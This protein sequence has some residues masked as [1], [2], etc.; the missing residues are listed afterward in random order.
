MFQIVTVYEELCS[1]VT[2]IARSLGITASV[3][4][5]EAMIYHW[6]TESN[7]LRDAYFIGLRGEEPLY[8]VM[9]L[10]LQSR[11]KPAD[12][13][14][15]P[16]ADWRREPELFRFATI[17]LHIEGRAIT[18][19]MQERYAFTMA[20]GMLLSAGGR[21]EQFAPK[22]IRERS[23]GQLMFC[24]T[25]AR[26]CIACG[27]KSESDHWYPSW[28]T[29]G[30]LCYACAMNHTK[31]HM[32]CTTCGM[33]PT[34]LEWA[35]SKH[36]AKTTGHGEQLYPC[37]SCNLNTGEDPY[38]LVHSA[39]LPGMRKCASCGTTESINWSK[40]W[41]TDRNYEL[42]GTCGRRWGNIKIHCECG[43]V[44]FVRQVNT[45]LAD[46]NGYKT[47]GCNECAKPISVGPE[48]LCISCHKMVTNI[49]RPSWSDS[50]GKLCVACGKLY[51][52]WQTYCKTCKRVPPETDLKKS[53]I[54]EHGNRVF[55]CRNCHP[56]ESKRKKT[57]CVSCGTT[58]STQWL[59]SWYSHRLLCNE[60]GCRYQQVKKYCAR[61]DFVFHSNTD[62][63]APSEYHGGS[64]CKCRRPD[65]SEVPSEGPKENTADP[66]VSLDVVNE[67]QMAEE[68]DL[69]KKVQGHT[70]SGTVTAP[71]PILQCIACKSTAN[72]RLRSSWN[73]AE[74][75]ICKKCWIRH[76][77][78]PVHCTECGFIPTHREWKKMEPLAKTVLENQI[79][80][81]LE[82]RRRQVEDPYTVVYAPPPEEPPARVCL[83]CGDTQGRD[84]HRS[85]VEGKYL[86]NCCGPRWKKIHAYCDG[87]GFVPFKKQI[88]RDVR[89][90]SVFNCQRCSKQTVMA[91]PRPETK[92]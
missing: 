20:S 52:A 25:P 86:C 75:K 44:P 37:P 59:P 66:E 10:T 67:S 43:S 35:H 69:G 90:C 22:G 72:E 31:H 65:P 77:K 27:N 28:S 24:A 85:W 76:M 21:N 41:G 3:Y 16:T 40:G 63:Q 78:H 73:N 30:S 12:R 9:L 19:H 8:R 33:V 13:W 64:R 4:K 7:K 32:H 87:C 47:F 62:P 81:C 91:D 11:K 45:A 53:K 15:V 39:T 82:C 34:V 74:G 61:C 23:S 5:R 55:K 2:A 18:L 51:A 38:T 50:E 26:L 29:E 36:L 83:S 6:H 68:S 70:D 71:G 88:S 46:D 84:W 48:R 17:P 92:D 49:W 56:S 60:C 42:C 14:E 89:G 1:R 54:D 58:D 80:P 79:F 57:T